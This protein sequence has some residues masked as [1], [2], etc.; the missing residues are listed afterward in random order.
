MHC[1]Y[2]QRAHRQFDA[3][4][5]SREH[6]LLYKHCVLFPRVFTFIVV[7]TRID[8]I[9][10]KL[11]KAIDD[12]PHVIRFYPD[13]KVVLLHRRTEA[14][15]PARSQAPGTI[16]YGGVQCPARRSKHLAVHE[17]RK[18]RGYE[19]IPNFPFRNETNEPPAA[20]G[21]SQLRGQRLI[22]RNR[23]LTARAFLACNEEIEIRTLRHRPQN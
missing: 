5:C 14:A 6:A 4:S 15:W 18:V 16:E 20:V 13:S 22:E 21:D 11:A 8:V 12:G 9:R 3:D 10:L 2:T 1:R 17:Q 19:K 7:P 23:P